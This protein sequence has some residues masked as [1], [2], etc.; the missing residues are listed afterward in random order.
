[1]FEYLTKSNIAIFGGLALASL[2]LPELLPNVRPTV[3]S[4]IKLGV[5]LLTESELEAEAELVEAL[6]AAT[7]D[8][9]RQDLSKPTIGTERSEAVQKRVEH[10]K[11]QAR[12]RA[13]RWARDPDDRHRR[14][15]RHVARLESSLA[16]QKQQIAQQDQQILDYAFGALGSEA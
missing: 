9:I 15:R 14:Y 3:R 1:M 11:H 10:F 12:T 2:A 13:R 5:D 16:M 7:M 8:G 6:V 4:V